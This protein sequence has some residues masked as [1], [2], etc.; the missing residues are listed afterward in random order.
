VGATVAARGHVLHVAHVGDSRCYRLR[1]GY[2]ERLTHDH[3]LLNDVLELHPD[4]ADEALARMPRKVV[5]RALGLEDNV[6]VAV[7]S[8]E[9]AHEDVYL[10]CSDG[11]TG[12]VSDEQ[13]RRVLGLPVSAEERALRLIRMAN[14]AGGGDNIAAVA[15]VCE[16][17]APTSV[18][19]AEVEVAAEERRD[20][21]MTSAPEIMVLG[22]EN[23]VDIEDTSRIRVVPS[24]SVSSGLIDTLGGF[25]RA[26][27]TG[28]TRCAACN[29][30]MV[31]EAMFCPHCGAR[32][33]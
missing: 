8:F 17:A 6:R 29:E 12:E 19:P 9:I 16:I 23:E 7:R 22:I 24:E 14:D 25:L 33:K 5:T 27:R 28:R 4:I 3:S 15:L 32:R 13:I 2:L 20:P 21:T 26:Y 31:A 1:G 11:L 30:V 18:E 10:L